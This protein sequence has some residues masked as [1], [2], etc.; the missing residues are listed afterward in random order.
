MA[1]ENRDEGSVQPAYPVVAGLAVPIEFGVALHAGAPIDAEGLTTIRADTATQLA[2]L[3]AVEMAL[4]E[5]RH[6]HVYDP[7][8]AAAADVALR[9]RAAIGSCEPPKSTRALW[10]CLYGCIS[11]PFLQHFSSAIGKDLGHA[12]AH[13]IIEVLSSLSH[14][15]NL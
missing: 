6:R 15:L 7:G 1:T 9:L 2:W 12:T 14:Y 8:F 5:L 3:D 10:L 4:R 13:E 11:V